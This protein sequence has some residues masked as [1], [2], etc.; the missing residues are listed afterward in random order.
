MFSGQESHFGR[1]FKNV[2]INLYLSFKS[3][4]LLKLNQCMHTPATKQGLHDLFLLKHM[5]KF[6][7]LESYL[8]FQYTQ[9][10]LGGAYH[11]TRKKKK[12]KK[13]KKKKKKKIECHLLLL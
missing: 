5:V 4:N 6:I 7:E 3:P 9:I 11:F 2:K 1:I 10:K 12:K 13:E 8:G